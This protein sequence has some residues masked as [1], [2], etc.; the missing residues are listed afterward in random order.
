MLTEGHTSYR[1]NMKI[2]RTFAESKNY[3]KHEEMKTPYDTRSN[4]QHFRKPK[5]KAAQQRSIALEN[6]KQ[7]LYKRI[8]LLPFLVHL[9]YILWPKKTSLI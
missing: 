6:S 7:L 1:Q 3:K 4:G 9:F 5:M 2:L 8:A